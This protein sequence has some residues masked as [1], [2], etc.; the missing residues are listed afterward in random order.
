MHG[1]EEDGVVSE[2]LVGNRMEEAGWNWEIEYQLNHN[3]FCVL[4]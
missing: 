2:S 1:L 3:E 4:V